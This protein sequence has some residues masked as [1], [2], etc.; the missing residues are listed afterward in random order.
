MKLGK[1]VVVPLVA[2]VALAT[3]TLAA[4]KANFSGTWV[5]DAA[6]SEGLPPGVEQTLT[7]TQEGDRV[8]LEL[9]VKNPQGEQKVKDGYT[10]DG[11]EV[12]FAPPPAVKTFTGICRR[13]ARAGARP[14]GRRTAAGSSSR[15]WLT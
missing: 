3:L 10:L 14:S 7:V 1:S 15:S 2:L 5:M 11:S 4:A 12:E 9:K 6:R 13:L 8:E